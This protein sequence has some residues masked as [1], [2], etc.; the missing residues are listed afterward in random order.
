M[1]AWLEDGD[2]H[3]LGI[4]FPCHDIA[5]SNKGSFNHQLNNFNS[6]DFHTVRSKINSKLRIVKQETLISI[7]HG[8]MHI[9][10]QVSRN[11]EAMSGNMN[12]GIDNCSPREFLQP[13][14]QYYQDPS[15]LDQG[16]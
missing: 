13:S 4:S 1:L 9:L 11:R 6:K 3:L 16:I 14:V 10:H 5:Q 12:S 15:T 8:S 7:L 2:F